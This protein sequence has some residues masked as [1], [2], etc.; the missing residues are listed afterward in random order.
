MSYNF[1]QGGDWSQGT[2]KVRENNQWKAIGTTDSTDDSTTTASSTGF[3]WAQTF[4]DTSWLSDADA[5]DTLNV[6]KVTNLDSSGTGSLRAA[7]NV[8]GPTVVVFEVGG[9]IN[10]TG[11]HI[12]ASAETWI[13]G[14]TA[15]SPGISII[16]GGLDISSDRVIASHL[17]MYA[18]DK[19]GE[20][21]AIAIRGD[22]Q[23]Y[24]HCSAF[25]G[26]DETIGMSDPQS[27]V[28]VINSIFAEGLDDSV[29]S[30]GPH[31]RGYLINEETSQKL[32]TMGCLA[33]TNNRRNPWSKADHVYINHMCFN[34]GSSPVEGSATN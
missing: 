13:A 24:D 15:P 28:S 27:R 17:G 9:V 3:E 34:H 29:H 33:A 22:D 10:V 8:T 30:E 12:D 19:H 14:E 20:I 6:E 16:E 11:S 25:W 26:V 32:C 4:T 23:I 1:P 7:A 18:G 2:P 5:N 21:E 31:S